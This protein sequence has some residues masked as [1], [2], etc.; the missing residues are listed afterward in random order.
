MM[1]LSRRQLLA[2]V[3]V[4]PFAAP[5]VARA[6]S[7]ELRLGLITPVGHSWNDAALRLAEALAQQTD[8]RLAMGWRH[9]LL[10]LPMTQLLAGEAA[11]AFDRKRGIMLE[12]RRS[13][14]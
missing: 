2:G 12:P 11:L 1:K 5:L 7:T 9:D 10:G 3:A 6:Q 14:D 13:S 8:G 4:L